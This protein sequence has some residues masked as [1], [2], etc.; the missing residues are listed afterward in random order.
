MFVFERAAGI[1]RRD[2]E[3][4]QEMQEMGIFLGTHNV[5]MEEIKKSLPS[6]AGY[7]DILCN[8][9]NICVSW[10]EQKQYLLPEEK[11]AIVKVGDPD[12]FWSENDHFA[13]N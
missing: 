6:I 11:Y 9:V 2:P 5:I 7:E 3:S 10:F 4:V 12:I 1:T 8:I 13:R